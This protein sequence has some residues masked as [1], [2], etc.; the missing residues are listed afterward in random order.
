[1]ATF[2]FNNHF[3][4]AMPTLEDPTFERSVALICQHDDKGAMGIVIN[5]SIPL[6]LG[7]VLEQ[8]DLSASTIN[9]PQRPIFSGGPVQPERGL[10]LHSRESEWDS[11]IPIGDTLAL[12]TSKDILEAMSENR[13]PSKALFALGYAGWTEGQLEREVGE[14]SWL[15]A[16]ADNDIIFN[17]P[18]EHR[19]FEA[20]ESVG[21]NLATVS[22]ETGHA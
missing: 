6:T 8:L 20:A 18:V 4:I 17:T 3:L 7:E 21:I 2:C 15:S 19:W 14:N 5:R 16:P 11:T 12:T 10:V 22:R 9:N 13:G 1:M